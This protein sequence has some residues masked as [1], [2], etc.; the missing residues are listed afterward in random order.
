[1]GGIFARGC[2]EFPPPVGIVVSLTAWRGP[3][4]HVGGSWL[5]CSRSLATAETGHLRATST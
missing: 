2:A 1:M 5:A 4:A 3:S